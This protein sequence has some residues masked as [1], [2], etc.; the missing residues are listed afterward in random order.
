MTTGYHRPNRSAFYAQHATRVPVAPATWATPGQQVEQFRGTAT[1]R[2]K[3]IMTLIAKDYMAAGA[4]P[5]WAQVVG[6]VA[7]AIAHQNPT[8][9]YGDVYESADDTAERGGEGLTTP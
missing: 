8:W 9:G 2:A 3:L 5:D 7:Y 1:D 6:L 4:H